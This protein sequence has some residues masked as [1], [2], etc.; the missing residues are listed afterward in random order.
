MS[1]KPQQAEFQVPTQEL[2]EFLINLKG[3]ICQ[4]PCILFRKTFVH[5]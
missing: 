1:L 4:Y 2:L 5:A 3:G